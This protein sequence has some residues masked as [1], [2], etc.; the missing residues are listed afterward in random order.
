M[1]GL[2]LAPGAPGPMPLPDH[3]HQPSGEA[4]GCGRTSVRAGLQSR[5]F[6]C[7]GGSQHR[8][9]TPLRPAGRTSVPLSRHST[10]NHHPPA[11]GGLQPHVRLQSARFL[12][13]SPS[14]YWVSQPSG[15][16]IGRTPQSARGLQ[17]RS[18]VTAPAPTL[19]RSLRLWGGLQ[20]ARDFSPAPLYTSAARFVRH[21][22]PSE[23]RPSLPSRDPQGAVLPL[24]HFH[25]PQ[26]RAPRRR[27]LSNLPRPPVLTTCSSAPLRASPRHEFLKCLLYFAILE[28]HE[29]DHHDPSARSHQ[30]RRQFEERVEFVQ[31][32][33]HRQ[34]QSH[35]GLRRWVQFPSP[36]RGQ[37][38]YTG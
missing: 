36:R 3:L 5:S 30:P 20:S 37:L 14:T 9:P 31:F 27:I 24:H 13:P 19:R 2:S 7:R 35:E 6:A 4:T 15:W 29:R 18:L 26:L 10:C 34:P 8:A 32:A 38:Y 28:R 11:V 23:R 25:R 17:S 12:S 33:I 21:Q 16:V 22:I 1:Y